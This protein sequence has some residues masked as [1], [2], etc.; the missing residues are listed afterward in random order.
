MVLTTLPYPPLPVL[1][2]RVETD[3]GRLLEDDRVI[4]SHALIANALDDSMA[5]NDQTLNQQRQ[6]RQQVV[7]QTF[8]HAMATEGFFCDP[9]RLYHIYCKSTLEHI[10]T[11]LPVGH[12][13]DIRFHPLSYAVKGDAVHAKMA[14]YMAGQ[15]LFFEDQPPVTREHY[16]QMTFAEMLLAARDRIGHAMTSEER[17]RLRAQEG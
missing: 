13:V 5:R 6:I 4:T 1:A 2:T 9:E 7:M 10:A 14:E 16:L 8:L 3:D 12:P 17:D 11:Y 15:S